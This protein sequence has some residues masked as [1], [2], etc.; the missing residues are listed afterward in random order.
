MVDW[1]DYKSRNEDADPYT[2][3]GTALQMA[4]GHTIWLV[5][6]VG[7]PTL[8]GGCSSLVTSF[9]VARGQPFEVLHGHGAFEIDNVDEFVAP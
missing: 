8:A 6:D 2:F 7:Y 3:A 4:A 1:V 5:Y 9:T